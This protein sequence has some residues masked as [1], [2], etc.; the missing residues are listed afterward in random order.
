[1]ALKLITAATVLAVSLVEAKAHLRVDS[2]DDD[3][4]I[5]SLIGASTQAAEH[6]T[7]RALMAQTWE[8][9]LDAFPSAIELTRV[10]VQS[11][12][13][14]TYADSIGVQTTMNNALYALD[15]A[16]E[17]GFAYVVP[18]YGGVWPATRGEINAVKVRYVAGYSDA[19]SVPAG[20]KQWILLQ[21]GAMYASREAETISMGQVHKLGFVDALL[22]RY[23]VYS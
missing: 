15:S 16:D 10:P 6:M 14:V 17:F 19:A 1:M 7:G 18:A 9:T 23:R 8:V 21:I 2:T 12:T 20:I 11:I 22:Q 5:T 3:T 13:S 4:L